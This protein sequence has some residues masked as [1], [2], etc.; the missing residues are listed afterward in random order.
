M[1]APFNQSNDLALAPER[2]EGGAPWKVFVFSLIFFGAVLGS[3]F[4]LIFGY[5]PYLN[6]R[7]AAVQSQIDDLA[8][9]VSV[10]EQSNLLRFYSQIVNL[11]TLL[12]SHVSLARF[13]PFLE[14]HTNS[15]VSYDIAFINSSTRELIL[16][17]LSE[18]YPVLAEELQALHQ[19]PE[20]KNYTLNQSQSAD[21]RIRFRITAKFAPE[22]F[23]Y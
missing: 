14:K 16:E 7:I 18:S 23:K 10:Q 3:Y 1:P 5:K 8:G 2:V 6:S 19:A 21:G 4:G 11:K 17:G 20:V 9:S 13:F 22:L 12:G 15:R